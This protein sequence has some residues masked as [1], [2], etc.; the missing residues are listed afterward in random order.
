VTAPQPGYL[1]NDNTNDEIISDKV[2]ERDL[3]YTSLSGFVIAGALA[4]GL[5]R[6]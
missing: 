6:L 2:E 4:V 5:A 3:V 1:D